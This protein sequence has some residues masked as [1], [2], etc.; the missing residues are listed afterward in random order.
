[1]PS[2]EYLF[3]K[4]NRRIGCWHSG[5]LVYAFGVI[6]KGTRLYTA[7]DRALADTM[8]GCWVS[9]VKTGDP[10]TVNGQVFA[11]SEDAS[12][13]MEFGEETGMIE[14]PWLPLYQIFDR[15]YGWN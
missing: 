1:M 3:T 10:G 5:E 8:H 6:P 15:M 2:W 14:D 7:E 4:D 12:Q 13:V 11:Q 9:F